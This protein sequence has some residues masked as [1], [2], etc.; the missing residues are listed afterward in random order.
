MNDE[1]EHK[2]RE[3]PS[4]DRRP[5]SEA[6]IHAA[7]VHPPQ[8][9]TS[10]I[11]IV[12]YTTEW[13]QRFRSEETRLRATLGA[14]VLMLEHT[15][16]TSVP[17]LAA[18]D[19]VDMLLVVA[20]SGDEP[21]YVP[22][23]E[24]AGYVLVIREP[25]WHQHRVFKGPKENINLHVLSEGSTEIARI[26]AFRDWLRTHPEDRRLYEDTKRW[27]AQRDWKYVQNY[28]DAKTDVIEEIIA[29]ALK[30]R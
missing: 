20:D 28:A 19:I 14:R 15:G 30:E 5:A 22:D 25:H 6:D 9:L 1:D 3:H 10:K 21:S 11:E 18:K 2:D 16:S 26:L 27:L 7:W 24:S 23:M 8:P 13:P 17:G 12:D 29:R 4:T